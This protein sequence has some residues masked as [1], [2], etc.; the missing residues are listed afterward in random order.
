M[1]SVIIEHNHN[2]QYNIQHWLSSLNLY[3]KSDLKEKLQKTLW[4]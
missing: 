2:E 1:N 3:V 4:F